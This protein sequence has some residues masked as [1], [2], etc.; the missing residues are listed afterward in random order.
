MRLLDICGPVWR[1]SW[2]LT[3]PLALATLAWLLP[4]WRDTRQFTIYHP[5]SM[6]RSSD[7]DLNL[8]QIALSRLA[9]IK[10]D[11]LSSWRSRWSA[12]TTSLPT[13]DLFVSS[14][15]LARLNSYLPK[16]G[17]EN[18]VTAKVR[19][20]DENLDKVHVRYRG[21]SLHHWG[22]AA[23]SW[24]I[25]TPKTELI[26]GARRWH[27]LL[28]RWRAV[29]SY[30]VNLRMANKMGLLAPEPT[31][32]N[33]RV[34]GRQHGGVHM[35]LPQQDEIFLRNHDRLPGDLYVGDMTPLDDDFPQEQRLTGLW[36]L[37]WLWQKSAV[38]NKFAATSHLPLEI[39]FQRLYHGTPAALAEML[40]LPAWARF[41]AYMQLFDAS[42]MD[43]G[44]NWKLYYNPGKLTFEPVLGD[45]NGLPDQINDVAKDSPGLDLSITTPLLVRLHQDHQFVRLKNE[46]LARFFST[47]LDETFFSE[48][49]AF[50]TK[51]TPTLEVYPQ[52]DWIGTVDGA[53]LH[54]FTAAELRRRADRVKP[55]LRRWFNAQRELA[56]LKA[57]NLRLC[58]L[59]DQILRLQIDGYAGAKVSL[60]ASAKAPLTTI[61]TYDENGRAESVD[62]SAYL[63][64]TAT[65][66]WLL[67]LSLLAERQITAPKAGGPPGKHEVR[68]A[69]YDLKFSGITVPARDIVLVGLLGEHV[70][71]LLADTL[72]PGQISSTNVHVIPAVLPPTQ[73]SGTMEILGVK[74]IIGDLTLSPGTRLRMGPDASLIVRGRLLALGTAEQPIIVERSNPAAAWGTLA[75]IGPR[76]DHTTLRHCRMS[77]G[78]GRNTPFEIFSGMVSIYDAKDVLIE[79]CRFSHNTVFDDLFHATYCELV[80]RDSVFLDA[81]S[82]GIDLDICRARL[83]RVVV[84]RTGND[85]LDFMTSDVTVLSSRLRHG[86]DKGIS[87]GEQSKLAVINSVVAENII[88]VQ[89]KDGSEVVIYNSVLEDNHTQLS[90]YHKNLSYPGHASIVAAKTR[91]V[92]GLMGYDLK[93][94]STVTLQDCQAPAHPPRPGL[95]RDNLSDSSATARSSEPAACFGLLPA[96][97]RWPG[98][99]HDVRGLADPA[100]LPVAELSSQP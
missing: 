19:F 96:D 21:D 100:A 71:P 99:R 98:A 89:A 81:F 79:N 33:L 34:N 27:V 54:Y 60:P 4:V 90:A 67:D 48:L 44:H 5:A 42:H 75:V 73:W 30:F 82:D 85:T 72:D 92:G 45:G 76:A 47:R 66:R 50:V 86:G 22:F 38:N 46:A 56:T 29:G 8:R 57:G 84:D 87:V 69:T 2:L 49:D 1:Y 15:G 9:S 65:G 70:Q 26:D 59:P 74:E 64:Q 28:P 53:P 63:V 61:T 78:S 52:L 80:I 20:P 39:L 94:S 41:A 83:E 17:K 37:P 23:K 68:P 58:A 14:G 16:S 31:L 24:L 88:G 7:V 36:E 93:D 6:H 25:R 43:M 13:V 11:L 77:G 35:L 18:W 12:G 51:V 55:D 32:V 62:A 3:M 40:D 95:T 91:L 97:R 10:A